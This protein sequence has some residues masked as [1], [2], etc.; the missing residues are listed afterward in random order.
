VSGADGR[1]TPRPCRVSEHPAGRV[2][3]PAD[4]NILRRGGWCFR[5]AS[6]HAP[7][8]GGSQ[9]LEKWVYL[10]PNALSIAHGDQFE[11]AMYRANLAG[12]QILITTHATLRN[13][14]VRALR[15]RHRGPARGQLWGEKEE[16]T[17]MSLIGRIAIQGGDER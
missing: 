16:R 14:V 8:L 17:V 13:R 1:P 4:P 11:N 9:E 12:T 7:S 5:L 6:S 3:R 15:R 2:S 10:A